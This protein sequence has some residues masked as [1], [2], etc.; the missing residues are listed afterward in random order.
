MQGAEK[1]VGVRTETGLANPVFELNGSPVEVVERPTQ[2]KVRFSFDTAIQ[3]QGGDRF[4]M[5]REA[6]QRAEKQTEEA[7]SPNG[8]T[9]FRVSPRDT[10][11][12][13]ITSSSDFE[14][15]K[16]LL[17]GSVGHVSVEGA[18]AEVLKYFN[19]ICERAT[20]DQLVIL[21][22]GFA[23]TLEI[24]PIPVKK[25]SINNNDVREITIFEQGII[26]EIEV[27]STSDALQ[28]IKIGPLEQLKKLK[29]SC[30][31][32]IVVDLSSNEKIDHLL[33]NAHGHIV[34]L[35]REHQKEFGDST[36]RGQKILIKG[37]QDGESITILPS[38]DGQGVQYKHTSFESAIR[39]VLNNEE[40][41]LNDEQQK[42]IGEWITK[43]ENTSGN[44]A[45]IDIRD[46]GDIQALEYAIKNEMLPPSAIEKGI[47][48]VNSSPNLLLALNECLKHNDWNI[49]V[50]SPEASNND[51]PTDYEYTDESGKPV[52][53]IR[54]RNSS[55]GPIVI[56][57]HNHIGTGNT[58]PFPN[59]S[60]SAETVRFLKNCV[61]AIFAILVVRTFFSSFNE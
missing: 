24:P 28:S 27:K 15:M 39:E 16:K 41:A 2:G 34:V 50:I 33:I 55:E 5:E 10:T 20:I 23:D 61:V 11:Y 7:I 13:T 59:V 43:I 56:H 8:R 21:S 4:L 25:L 29:I 52:L 22:N 35:N 37:K 6:E 14:L 45:M 60:F 18:T 12:L 49:P 3:G 26:Q 40:A 47:R 44:S 1:P 46:I 54:N 36:I 58:A 30:A 42:R 19:E 17:K 48:L 9:L 57:L 32:D 53:A 31:S 51:M 38:E